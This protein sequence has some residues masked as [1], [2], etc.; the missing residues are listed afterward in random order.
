MFS[1]GLNL[2]IGSA[3]FL[4]LPLLVAPS[5]HPSLILVP[6]LFI[7][8]YFLALWQYLHRAAADHRGRAQLVRR[9]QHASGGGAST[10]SR[11]VKGQ[12]QEQEEVAR[13]SE[14]ARHL[15]R[16]LHPPGRRRSA[17]PALASPGAGRQPAPCCMP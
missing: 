7:M 1:P 16:R 5:Y 13:F 10:G 4:I 3:N 14:N 8:A 9:P 6:A 11:S 2:V 12:A 15:P 17:L